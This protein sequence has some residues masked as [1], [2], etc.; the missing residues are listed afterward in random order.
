MDHVFAGNPNAKN[1][2][3]RFGFAWD[4]SKDHKTS[5]RGGF[6]IFHDQIAPRWYASGY[7]LAPPFSFGL[8]IAPPFPNPYPN[9]VPTGKTPTGVS[10]L[11]YTWSRC[12]DEDS[13]SFG[14]EGAGNITD[15]YNA[16][17]DYGRCNFDIGRT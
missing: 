9:Y 15:P 16:H 6:G 8:Q 3:P 13:G 10:I 14:L 7:Y 12:L 5:V 2:D 1:F 11:A 4:P 17:L